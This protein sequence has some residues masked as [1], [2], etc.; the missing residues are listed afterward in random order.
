M[1]FVKFFISCTNFV[2]VNIIYK[3]C[4][5]F[6]CYKGGI[7]WIIDHFFAVVVKDVADVFSALKFVE[8]VDVVDIAVNVVDSFWYIFR[9]YPKL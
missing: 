4:L 1:Y 2:V 6:V 7:L 3:E 5:F 8:D 9:V